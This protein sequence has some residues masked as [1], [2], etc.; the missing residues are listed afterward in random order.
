MI[1]D[2]YHIG[3]DFDILIQKY[4]LRSRKILDLSKSS[5]LSILAEI[6]HD[7]G[8]SRSWSHV[9]M[10]NVSFFKDLN[11]DVY[12]DVGMKGFQNFQSIHFVHLYRFKYL[13]L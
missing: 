10:A 3:C 2:F 12:G 13:L 9:K 4:Q 1:N 6:N 8:S 11:G 5:T 7:L